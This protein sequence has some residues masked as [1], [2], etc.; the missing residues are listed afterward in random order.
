MHV[1]EEHDGTE[2]DLPEGDPTK[3]ETKDEIREANRDDGDEE[4]LLSK[5]FAHEETPGGDPADNNLIEVAP[6]TWT[7][8][9]ACRAQRHEDGHEQCEGKE[10]RS[11][12]EATESH[13]SDRGQVGK[14]IHDLGVYIDQ[15][16]DD[17]CVENKKP[18]AQAPW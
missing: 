1:D 9:D 14:V 8:K 3:A 11:R 6:D 12:E 7:N 2:K 4:R 18:E 15:A 17:E 16:S 13:L 10:D 5:D